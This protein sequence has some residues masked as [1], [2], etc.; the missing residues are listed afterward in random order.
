MRTVGGVII[1]VFRVPTG[2]LL[3]FLNPTHLASTHVEPGEARDAMPGE[4]ARQ[5]VGVLHSW[6]APLAVEVA[7]VAA[8]QVARAGRV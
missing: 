6:P 7:L 1:V 8:F 3:N 5:Q 2:E 4:S